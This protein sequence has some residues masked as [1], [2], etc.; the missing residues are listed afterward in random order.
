MKIA[1][2]LFMLVV[3]LHSAV[4]CDIC[5]GI[6]SNVSSEMLLNERFHLLGIRSVNRLTTSYIDGIRHSREMIFSQE[7]YSRIQVGNRI[8]FIAAIPYQTAVQ[9]RDLGHDF[10]AGIGDPYAYING[11]LLHRKD[12]LGTTRT[13]ISL[14]GGAKFPIGKFSLSQDGFQNLYPGT[15]SWDGLVS[16]NFF[17]VLKRQFSIQCDG[18]YSIKTNNSVGFRYG[19]AYIA[20]A[21]LARYSNKNGKRLIYGGGWYLERF[22]KSVSMKTDLGPNDNSGY[23]TGIRLNAN[24]ITRQWLFT[25]QINLPI[26]QSLNN[27]N[28]KSNGVVQLGVL[29]LL[30]SNVK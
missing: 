26:L 23:T 11:I 30:N 1:V 17:N 20:S 16:L 9:K 28:V 4:C 13:F 19:N 24:I 8:Q 21:Q 15:G 10:F 18:S 12:S 6:G 27:G 2:H 3:T 5:G 14:G 7:V 25:S 22:E 29:Y